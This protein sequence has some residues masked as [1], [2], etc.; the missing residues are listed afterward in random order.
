MRLCARA[1]TRCWTHCRRAIFRRHAAGQCLDVQT[2]SRRGK[3]FRLGQHLH[4]GQ[5]LRPH[6]VNVIQRLACRRQ[7]RD[8]RLSPL[9]RHLN[10]RLGAGHP[11][12]PTEGKVPGQAS[13]GSPENRRQA[14]PF[15]DAA[16]HRRDWRVEPDVPELQIQR[17]VGEEPGCAADVVMIDVGDNGEVNP[18]PASSVQGDRLQAIHQHGDAFVRSG[19][20][21]KPPGTPADRAG[22][23]QA[24]AVARG[25]CLD[26][27]RWGAHRWSADVTPS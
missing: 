15:P 21:E 25:K 26:G 14:N 9:A 4:L 6:P 2:A 18:S 22:D 3:R 17:R 7:K 16:D 13:R 27:D 23:Q 20:D 19:I 1:R 12:A 24:V 5:F 11:I 10:E 8:P